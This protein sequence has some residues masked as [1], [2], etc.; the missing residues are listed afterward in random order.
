MEEDKAV[1]RGRCA[2]A[3]TSALC[4]LEGRRKLWRQKIARFE[5]IKGI[6][7]IMWEIGVREKSERNCVC[8]GGNHSK[9][10]ATFCLKFSHNFLITI[11]FWRLRF[12]LFELASREHF[13]LPILINMKDFVLYCTLP[14]VRIYLIYLHMEYQVIKHT[15]LMEV[16]LAKFRSIIKKTAFLIYWHITTLTI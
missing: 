4:M 6:R 2:S 16:T 3:C 10:H 5:W 9:Q 11:L 15:N 13:F 14:P 12:T 1:E 7:E 8:K